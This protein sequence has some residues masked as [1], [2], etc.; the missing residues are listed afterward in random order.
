MQDCSYVCASPK[1]A[2]V[3]RMLT[4]VKMAK[5]WDGHDAP[6]TIRLPKFA[7]IIGKVRIFGNTTSNTP[8]QTYPKISKIWNQKNFPK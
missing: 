3:V 7:P 5:L 2:N 1:M 4:L 8:F 6:S